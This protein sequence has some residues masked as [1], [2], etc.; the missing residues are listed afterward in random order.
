MNQR[1]CA[2]RVVL[3]LRAARSASKA[4]FRLRPVVRSVR[5]TESLMLIVQGSVTALSCMMMTHNKV[6]N[7]SQFFWFP[8]SFT[9]SLSLPL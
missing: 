2:M 8:F 9:L 3:P 6:K 4:G 1:T 7:N 5:R